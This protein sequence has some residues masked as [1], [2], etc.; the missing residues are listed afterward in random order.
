[1]YCICFILTCRICFRCAA[2]KANGNILSMH[3]MYG[4]F[5]LGENLTNLCLVISHLL[6]A[7][8]LILRVYY[9]IY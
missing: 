9:I 5:V 6:I 1:M 4:F 7:A 8:V 2:R 3:L